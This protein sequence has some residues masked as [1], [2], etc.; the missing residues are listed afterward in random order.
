MINNITGVVAD[1][2]SRFKVFVDADVLA[3]HAAFSAQ[4]TYYDVFL[5]NGQCITFD[6]AKDRDAWLKSNEGGYTAVEARIDVQSE[7][8]ALGHID[9]ILKVMAN[10]IKRAEWVLV[11]SHPSREQNFRHKVA[12]TKPYKGN[13]QSPKPVHYQAVVD[14]LIKDLRAIDGIDIP[15]Y[16]AYGYEADDLIRIMSQDTYELL[17]RNSLNEPDV[18]LIAVV[19]SVDKDLRMINGNHYNWKTGDKY[20]VSLWD[21][22]RWFMTQLLTGDATDN[23][24]GLPRVGEKTAANILEGSSSLAEMFKRVQ[25]AYT[26]KGFD[27]AYLT[28]QGQLLW[29]CE[30]EGQRWTPGW[31]A[32]EVMWFDATIEAQS[33]SEGEGR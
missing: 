16:I 15:A 9:R 18:A 17:P 13:R 6:N 3:Y 22:Q 23:I 32:N 11:L 5:N 10:D 24:P 2:T 19:A 27:E 29:L 12:T 25:D 20:K 8:V 7:E 31:Y 33:S 4:H 26:E 28:E 21:S 1:D 14:S 30:W